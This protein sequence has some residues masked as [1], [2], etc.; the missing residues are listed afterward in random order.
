MFLRLWR[1]QPG[2]LGI[3][4]STSRGSHESLLDSDFGED[5]FPLLHNRRRTHIHRRPRERLTNT[6]IC[7]RFESERVASERVSSFASEMVLLP[8]MSLAA[9]LTAHPAKLRLR[10]PPNRCCDRG[11]K[12]G[13]IVALRR[14]SRGKL[15]LWKIRLM[16]SPNKAEHGLTIGLSEDACATSRK[17]QKSP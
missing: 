17:P 1:A 16:I 5:K 7:V 10:L 12:L 13:S 14:N 11:E 2:L 9:M 6:A 3:S 4:A 15:P 8:N